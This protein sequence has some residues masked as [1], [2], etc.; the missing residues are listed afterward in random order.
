M[1][2][3]AKTSTIGH[4]SS[5]ASIHFLMGSA[6]TQR[7]APLGPWFFRCSSVTEA[8]KLIVHDLGR[9]PCWYHA[10]GAEIIHGS[11]GWR[12]LFLKFV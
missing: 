6:T 12:S 9:F 4:F 10:D 8:F 3:D 11:Q 1:H 5:A 2:P 7:S